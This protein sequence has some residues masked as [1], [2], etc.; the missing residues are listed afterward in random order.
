MEESLSPRGFVR[1]HRSTVVNIARIREIQPWFSGE[2]LVVL[3]DGTKLT[4][5]RAYRSALQALME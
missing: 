4:S 5:S 1:I 3:R 2:Y